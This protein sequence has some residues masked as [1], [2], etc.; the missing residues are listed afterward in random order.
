MLI[1][2]MIGFGPIGSLDKKRPACGEAVST[3]Y[4]LCIWGTI[5]TASPAFALIVGLKPMGRLS[6]KISQRSELEAL[7]FTFRKPR[8]RVVLA[9]GP[10]D[11]ITTGGQGRRNRSGC[12]SQMLV[13]GVLLVVQIGDLD[14]IKS[15]VLE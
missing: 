8:H 2:S 12:S 1:F 9:I 10:D 13:F 7:F 15:K 14:S 6:G 5:I 3:Q 4:K 11:R